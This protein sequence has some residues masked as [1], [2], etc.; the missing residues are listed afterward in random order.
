MKNDLTNR[1]KKCNIPRAH[2]LLEAL[3]IQLL[4]VLILLKLVMILPTVD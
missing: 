2:A 3:T 1:L 4:L